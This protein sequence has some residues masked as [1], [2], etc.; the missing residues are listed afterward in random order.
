MIKILFAIAVLLIAS[1]ASA[2]QCNTSCNTVGG[3]TSCNTYCW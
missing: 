2:R 1:E 3:Y